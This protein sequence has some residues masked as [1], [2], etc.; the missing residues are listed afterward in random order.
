MTAI[1]SRTASHQNG[2]RSHHARICLDFKL[3]HLSRFAQSKTEAGAFTEKTFGE[4]DR[5]T[6]IDKLISSVYQ[7]VQQFLT[8]TK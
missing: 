5:L 8:V 2:H 7:P 1:F 3:T 4:P 6:L